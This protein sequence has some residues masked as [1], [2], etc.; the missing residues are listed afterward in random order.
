VTEQLAMFPLELGRRR[1]HVEH[2]RARATDPPTSHEAAERNA[3]G[4]GKQLQAVLDLIRRYPGH[5]ACELAKRAATTEADYVRLRFAISRRA[6]ELKADG[7]IRS[8][9]ARVCTVAGSR[10]TVWYAL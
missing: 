2:A 8:G 7:L 4:L 5:T 1:V 10:Q 9:T 6:A 3:A